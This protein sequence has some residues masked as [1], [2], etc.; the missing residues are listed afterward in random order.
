MPKKNIISLYTDGSCS[1]NPGPGG[2]AFYITDGKEHYSLSGGHHN[3]TNNEMELTAIMQ[4]LASPLKAGHII[5]YTDSMYCIGV[6]SKGHRVLA[7]K[8]LV[9]VTKSMM[10]I[11]LAV[12]FVHVKGHSGDPHNELVDK[13]AKE[14]LEAY[15]IEDTIEH[16]GKRGVIHKAKRTV[17]KRQQGK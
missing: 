5:V 15:R 7:N 16:E 14:A 17:A 9:E 4:G 2:W 12:E 1:P 8:I 11:H 13:L 6:L 3:T 10:S